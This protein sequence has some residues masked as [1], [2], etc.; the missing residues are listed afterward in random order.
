MFFIFLSRLN[1]K[2]N[3]I[4]ETKPIEENLLCEINLVFLRKENLNQF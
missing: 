2:A 4:I 3:A 1:A